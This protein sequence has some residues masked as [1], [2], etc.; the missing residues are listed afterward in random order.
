MPPA[1]DN[2]PKKSPSPTPPKGPSLWVQLLIALGIFILI[3][4][5]YSLVEQYM[6]QQSQTVPISQIAEDIASNQIDKVV[7]SG[8]SVTAT[9]ADGTKKV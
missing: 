7:V 9:Y 1:P 2:T 8:D 5:G 3:S 4:G 6:T